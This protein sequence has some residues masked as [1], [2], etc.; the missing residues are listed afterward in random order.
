MSDKIK[1]EQQQYWRSLEARAAGGEVFDPVPDSAGHSSD[2]S[3]S[4]R[5]FLTLMGASM[6]MAGLAS[7]RRPKERIIPYVQAPEEIV[8][9]NPKQY[10]T[11]MPFGNRSYGALVTTHEG[12]PTKIEGNPLH[13]SSLGAASAYMQASILDLYDP[14]RA[15]G[16]VH[17]GVDAS[18]DYFVAHWKTLEEKFLA[19]EGEG[20]A[21]L[22]EPFAS[23]TLFRLKREFEKRFPRA[24]WATWEP[25]SD[26]NVVKGRKL[27][28]YTPS[29]DHRQVYRLD[30]AKVIVAVDSDFLLGEPES[31][32][33][34]RG[35]A[36]GRKVATE[37]DEMNRLYVVESAHTVTGASAD[38]RL[39]LKPSEIGPFLKALAVELKKQGL[40]LGDIPESHGFGEHSQSIAVMA[41]D[42]M[43]AQGSAVIL[44]GLHLSPEVHGLVALLNDVMA[45]EPIVRWVRGGSSSVADTSALGSFAADVSE[46]HIDTMVILSGNPVFDMPADVDFKRLLKNTRNTM[47]VSLHRNETAQECNWYLPKAHY[48]ESW[49]D[50]RAADSTY[51]VIQPTIEPLHGAKSEVELLSL[52]VSGTDKSSHEI[53]RDTFKWMMSSGDFEKSWQRVLH[54]GIVRL[55]PE[56]PGPRP[57]PNAA[58]SILENRVFARQVTEASN[59]EVIFT[60]SYST[61][62]GRFANNGWLQELPDPVTKLAW[63]NAA[64]ISPTTANEFDLVNGDIVTL[65]LKGRSIEIPIWIVPGQADQTVILPLGYGRTQAG[66]VGS[67][68]GV[69]TY[70][71]RTTDAMHF[72]TGLSM[73]KTGRR[74]DDMANTQDHSSMEGRPIVRE[75]TLDEYK[76]HPE[77]AREM[78]EHPPLT[79]LWEE[80]DYSEGYQWG[81]AIDLNACI[82]CNACVVACQSENNIPVVGREQVQKGREMHWLRV[83]RYFNGEPENA[84]MVHQPV[85]CQHCENAPCEQVCPVAATVHDKE[86]LN[87]MVYNRCIGTRYCANNCPYKVRRFNFFNFTKDIPETTQMAQNPDVTVR[88]RGVME[89]CTYCTQRINRARRDTKLAG[90]KLNDGDVVTACQQTCPTGAIVFGDINDPNSEVS[91]VKKRNRG[92][93][94]LSEL[95][96]KPRTSFLA[97]I[98][99][100]NPELEES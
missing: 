68:V 92:Y 40:N 26:E 49:S 61:Y 14:D 16:V 22:A 80:H 1:I 6:A 15:G 51:S 35:F 94:L 52:M 74:R 85:A 25:V 59:L 36:S 31:I 98:R 19:N 18:W 24:T 29:E 89:K 57:N 87:T 44:A 8:P 43:A 55:E 83:D 73:T 66:R 46:G 53:V 76:K 81:M 72:A 38:H 97:K 4:R 20:L 34:A 67:N 70:E 42:L 33:M 48:L 50:A 95:N 9:G 63:D 23:P 69:N 11:T 54:D 47:H 62:D 41:R 27:A 37:N 96:V 56:G 2:N 65:A 3:W 75:A 21:V 99:N 10:A 86:G 39:R 84:L 77:F 78:V 90:A 5:S 28:S 17:D 93:E 64:L 7:C 12:R 82:G 88:S 60:P 71:L 45:G 30:L 58:K 32:T 91:K 100:P 79:S 13:P